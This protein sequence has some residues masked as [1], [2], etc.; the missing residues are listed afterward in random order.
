MELLRF[1][2]DAYCRLMS[3]VGQLLA[4]FNIASTGQAA[5]A[6]LS[7]NSEAYEHLART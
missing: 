2:A 5:R 4:H 6:G 1:E 7:V 3:M